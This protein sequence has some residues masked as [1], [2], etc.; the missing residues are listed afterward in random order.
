MALQDQ[1]MTDMKDAM[2]NKDSMRLEAL[3]AVKAA[4]LLAKTEKSGGATLNEEEE[5]KLVQKLVKQRKDSAAI[6]KEQG[7]EDLA[8]PE[9]AQAEVIQKYLP[10]QLSEAEIE[11]E[12]DQV[13]AQT[14]ADGMKDMGKVMG[15]VSK[16]LAGKADGKTISG[17]VRSKLQ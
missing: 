10:E 9:L 7:R 16:K 14:G 4:L 5:I 17:I 15:M 2:R 3:R 6:Y 11:K 8:E 13:I 1:I 12:V